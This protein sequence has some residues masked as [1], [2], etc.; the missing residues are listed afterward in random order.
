MYFIDI[1]CKIETLFAQKSS[2]TLEHAQIG[3][4][5]EME[6]TYTKCGDYYIPDLVLDGDTERPLGRFGRMRQ[7]FLREYHHSTY[8]SM[9]LTGRLNDHLD[10]IDRSADEMMD[11]LTAQMTKAEG[12]TEALKATDQMEWVQKMN[13]IR[14]RAEEAVLNDLVYA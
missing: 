8:T 14:S 6:L 11:R 12:V 2:L 7:R 1:D 5:Y 10:E 3:K 4:E 9:L 13:S